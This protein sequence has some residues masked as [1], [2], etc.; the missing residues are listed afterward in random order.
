[1][2]F[3]SYCPE[4]FSVIFDHINRHESYTFN[5]TTISVN[6]VHTILCMDCWQV[7]NY[8]ASMKTCPPLNMKCTHLNVKCPP[9]HLEIH[10][11]YSNC[12]PLYTLLETT[13]RR[14]T[15]SHQTAPK[16]DTSWL[17]S[18]GPRVITFVRVTYFAILAWQCLFTFTYLKCPTQ[19]DKY[20]YNSVGLA[21]ARPTSWW[22]FQ[23]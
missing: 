22:A 11:P 20:K 5:H 18:R 4:L 6:V 1:M 10:S 13:L 9:S 19:T 2:L 23:A 16:K 14:A 3:G 8:M 15:F 21:H 12:K 7:E 17:V